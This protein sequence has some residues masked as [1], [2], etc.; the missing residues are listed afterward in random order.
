MKTTNG[1]A[2]WLAQSPSST[3]NLRGIHFPQDATSGYLVGNFGTIRKTAN[4]QTWSPEFS[5]TNSTLRDVQFPAEIT[6]GY[7]VGTTAPS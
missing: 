1:G 2:N 4:G 7:A 3:Q 6:S 5:G